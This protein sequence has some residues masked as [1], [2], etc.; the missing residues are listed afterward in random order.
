MP[1]QLRQMKTGKGGKECCEL[2]C[3]APTTPLG[4]GIE[5][6]RK[7]QKKKKKNCPTLCDIIFMKELNKFAKVVLVNKDTI[8][9][10]VQMDLSD[11]FIRLTSDVV[12]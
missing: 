4:H 9:L 11:F 3:G 2:I 12:S 10:K 7:G 8:S 1:A 6:N 5:Y